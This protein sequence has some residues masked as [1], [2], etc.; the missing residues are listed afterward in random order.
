VSTP[1]CFIDT[2][3]TSLGPDRRAWEVAI[4][5]HDADG[6]P[7]MRVMQVDDVSLHEAD[8]KSLDIGG[9]YARHCDYGKP[10][11]EVEAGPERAVARWVEEWTRGAMLIGINPAFDTE[12]L[13][14]MLRRHNLV[15]AWHYTVID[16]KA[17][18]AGYLYR[19]AFALVDKDGDNQGLG[20][21]LQWP[22][23]TEALAQACGVPLPSD[24]VRHTALGDAIFAESWWFQLL[25]GG[26]A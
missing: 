5:R 12:V 9:F 24:E 3:T 23:K 11:P 7:Q 20:I 13:S 6:D 18:A 1:F 17:M 25:T 22:F 15:P 2:E 14:A 8:P 19:H 26:A 4:I 10:G 21:A 16:L